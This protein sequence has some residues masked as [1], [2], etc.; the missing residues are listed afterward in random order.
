M[1]GIGCRYFINSESK[2]GSV[3]KR[4]NSIS[5]KAH[6]ILCIIPH[7]YSPSL[8]LLV[9]KYTLLPLLKDTLYFFMFPRKDGHIPLTFN[10]ISLSCHAS[11]SF[12]TQCSALFNICLIRKS[13]K[14]T[15][16]PANNID[17]HFNFPSLKTK[18]VL[19]F[20]ISPPAQSTQ[21]FPLCCQRAK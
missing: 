11:A 13:L 8:S 15:A 18:F 7:P 2:L 16:I 3:P 12:S 10:P 21:A 14:F 17:N 6:A 19:K 4:R 1:F 9:D 5:G 20:R